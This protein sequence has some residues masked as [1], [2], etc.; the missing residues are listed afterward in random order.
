MKSTPLAMIRSLLASPS[1]T[2]L[3]IRPGS[4]PSATVSE[5]RAPSSVSWA[6]FFLTMSRTSFSRAIK[7]VSFVSCDL[8]C[9][10]ERGTNNEREAQTGYNKVQML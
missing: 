6:T 8:F 3:R 9:F 5:L 4:T 7:F 10:I 2:S 1:T